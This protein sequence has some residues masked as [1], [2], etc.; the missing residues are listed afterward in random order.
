[1]TTREHRAD[2]ATRSARG[3]RP[4]RRRAV[5]AAS[6]LAALALILGA[7]GEEGTAEE[8]VG[9]ATSAV[10]SVAA[11][12]TSAVGDATDGDGPTTGEQPAPDGDGG[13]DR[14]P[15]EQF[16]S[17]IRTV[18]VD[19]EDEQGYLTRG[20]DACA[21]LD[22]DMGYVDVVRQYNDAHADAPVTE[23]PV[24]VAAAVR[25]FC[26]QHLPQVGQDEGGNQGG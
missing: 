4:V 10:G 9:E 1:M 19:A 14:S 3:V 26:P 23:A 5:A 11:E 6:G 20:R 13:D 22:G 25:A 12:A 2:Q 24:V 17:E 21:S 7:C 16:L 18:G 15:E 8:A